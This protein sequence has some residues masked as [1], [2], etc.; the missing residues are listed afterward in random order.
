[1]GK[2]STQ[3]GGRNSFDAF[4][5]AINKET[6]RK[7]MQYHKINETWVLP[8]RMKKSW[9]LTDKPVNIDLAKIVSEDAMAELEAE[10]GRSRAPKKLTGQAPTYRDPFDPSSTKE[11]QVTM[12]EDYGWYPL[13][14][15]R[16]I[17]PLFRKPR[18]ATEITK[19]Y[20][21][22]ER[23][24]GNPNLNSERRK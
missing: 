6:I 1:M 2:E 9:I 5:D 16:D 17:C 20:G 4:Q 13:P 3:A 22:G 19:L 23:K 7:E 24:K 8:P 11:K 18:V 21:P 14:L 10:L 12:A 15:Q